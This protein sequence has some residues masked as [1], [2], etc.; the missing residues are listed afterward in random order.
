MEELWALAW[1]IATIVIFYGVAVGS[2]LTV[3]IGAVILFGGLLVTQ[4]EY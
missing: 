1:V 4:N 2:G 3:L